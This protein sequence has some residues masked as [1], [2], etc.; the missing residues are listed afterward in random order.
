MSNNRTGQ[1]F[2]DYYEKKMST[3]GKTTMSEKAKYSQEKK[4][5]RLRKTQEAMNNM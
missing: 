3:T 5:E 2:I 4:K 1:D